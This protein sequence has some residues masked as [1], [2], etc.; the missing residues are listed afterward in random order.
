MYGGDLPLIK[1][2]WPG[3]YPTLFRHLRDMA[4]SS[5]CRLLI[6]ETFFFPFPKIFLTFHHSSFVELQVLVPEKLHVLAVLRSLTSIGC[7]CR[8]WSGQ[9]GFWACGVID[10]NLPLSSIALPLSLFFSLSQILLL[11]LRTSSHTHTIIIIWINWP[12]SLV[13]H[14]K[15]SSSGKYSSQNI[16]YLSTAL[17]LLGLFSHIMD[18]SAQ[19]TSIRSF[20]SSSSSS[21]SPPTPPT[22]TPTCT[23]PLLAANTLVTP[24]PS[25]PSPYRLPD[26]FI[27]PH[28]LF[29]ITDFNLQIPR[30]AWGTFCLDQCIAYA[31]THNANGTCRSFAVDQGVPYPPPPEGQDRRKRWWCEG[32]DVPL[33]E[34]GFVENR[35]PGS[36]ER[37]AGVNRVCGG[38]YR[39][40]WADVVGGFGWD[41]GRGG[42]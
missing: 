32:F 2:N 24:T 41:W 27:Y 22:K 3:R 1:L 13:S 34:E 11:L 7:L 17:T 25:I 15:S 21:S 37:F 20:S 40:F 9:L 36:Y 4:L 42:G 26:T 39:D 16:M 38:S 12:L 18:I 30:A 35:V 19:S 10:M 28:I 23:H 33:S 29:V 5:I 6:Q 31:Y 8:D 14:K